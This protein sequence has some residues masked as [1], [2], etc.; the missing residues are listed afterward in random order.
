M[1]KLKK[2]VEIQLESWE[3]IGRY[4]PTLPQVGK[5]MI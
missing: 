4:V 1:Q 3:N 2:T 5:I